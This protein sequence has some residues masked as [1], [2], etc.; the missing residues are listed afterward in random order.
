LYINTFANLIFVSGMERS[1]FPETI[2]WV[3]GNRTSFP[4]QQILTLAKVLYIKKDLNL[5]TTIQSLL[6]YNPCSCR[7]YSPTKHGVSEDDS[8]FD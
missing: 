3:S 5:D 2:T 6:I 4:K 1:G 8:R 7:V